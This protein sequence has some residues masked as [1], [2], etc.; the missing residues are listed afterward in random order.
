MSNEQTKQ[1]TEPLETVYSC[2]FPEVQA[3]VENFQKRL[4]YKFLRL[5]ANHDL[6]NLASPLF[7]LYQEKMEADNQAKNWP[8]N[9]YY[10]N[11]S[12]EALFHLVAHTNQK[13]LPFYQLN[14]EYQGYNAYAETL[15]REFINVSHDP[16]EIR[17]LEPGIFFVSNPSAVHGNILKEELFE[18][19]LENHQVVLDLAYL[20]MTEGINFDLGHKNILAVVASMSKPFGLYYFRI[21]FCWSK[22]E[23]PSL[24]G[25]KWFKNANSILLGQEVLQ[26][27]LPEFRKKGKLCSEKSFKANHFQ[28]TWSQLMFF[29]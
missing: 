21:G 24:Y 2:F 18:A 17:N 23:L 19:I 12:S 25:N 29:Y 9:R 11:G 13:N 14:G 20:G 27:N 7:D 4:D 5:N 15:G 16:K 8:K 22:E 3:I 10:V 1:K 26:I 6:D 28:K